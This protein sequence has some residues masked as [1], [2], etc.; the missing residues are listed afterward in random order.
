M[1]PMNVVSDTALLVS[2]VCTVV[3]PPLLQVKY[4]YY[5]L[6][7]VCRTIRTELSRTTRTNIHL[8]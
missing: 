3:S 6:D 8:S 2:T 1:E 4:G 5:V 7:M